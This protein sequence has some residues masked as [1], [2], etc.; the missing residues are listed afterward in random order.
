LFVCLF[1]C[2][3]FNGDLEFIVIPFSGADTVWKS[4]KTHGLFAH[5]VSNKKQAQVTYWSVCDLL[6]AL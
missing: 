3:I 4:P 6:S 5:G 2:F 1:A